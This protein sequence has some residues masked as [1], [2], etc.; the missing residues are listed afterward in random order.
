VGRAAAFVALVLSG[1]SSFA[2]APPRAI[3]TSYDRDTQRSII[4]D[5]SDGFQ[6]RFNNRVRP[7]FGGPGIA[8]GPQLA[9]PTNQMRSVRPLIR[10]FTDQ[11][12]QLASLLSDELRRIPSIRSQ[13]SEVMQVSALAA[14][15]DK[16]AQ[17][18]NDLG[19]LQD[20]FR[21][22]DAAWR[23]LAYRLGSIRLLQKPTVDAIVA[24]NDLDEQIR[25]AIGMPRRAIAA[26]WGRSA[27]T[28]PTISRT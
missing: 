9:A 22:L 27:M 14:T 19:Q 8:P 2:Q 4:N 24:L 20:E 11:S 25:D 26:T 17:R 12:G 23:T 16:D 7:G 21:Q 28:W 5:L 1:T 6:D 13:Y 18:F 15:L 3:Q 10:Q